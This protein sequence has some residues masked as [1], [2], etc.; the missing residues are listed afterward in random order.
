[1]LFFSC[2]ITVVLAILI[3]FLVFEK[4][5]IDCNLEETNCTTLIITPSTGVFEVDE[6]L[7]VLTES[8]LTENGKLVK[9][10]VNVDFKGTF[11]QIGKHRQITACLFRK[12]PE[13]SHSNY[14]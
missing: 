14:L 2:K 6:E 1:M 3:I 13:I 9:L 10:L 4:N 8:R 5:Y 12:Y 11:M 7:A